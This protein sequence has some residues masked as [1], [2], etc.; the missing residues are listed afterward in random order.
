MVD[1]Y[2]GTSAINVEHNED[3]C[4]K[5]VQGLRGV[6]R[7][8]GTVPLRN[9]GS[10]SKKWRHWQPRIEESTVSSRKNDQIC[11]QRMSNTNS[12]RNGTTSRPRS[13]S[14]TLR[15]IAAQ[16]QNE[17]H[18]GGP[19][20]SS[21]FPHRSTPY[22]TSQQRS[23]TTTPTYTHTPTPIHWIL[24]SHHSS[25][26]F[27]ESLDAYF[28]WEG[29]PSFLLKLFSEIVGGHFLQVATA[30]LMYETV[31][32]TNIAGRRVGWLGLQ[33]GQCRCCLMVCWTSPVFSPSWVA[34]GFLDACTALIPMAEGDSTPWCTPTRPSCLGLD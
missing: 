15:S 11:R 25:T 14:R 6:P 24:D 2:E 26:T 19:L 12:L 34:K 22:G 20:P 28:R 32:I 8:K 7:V 9:D 5:A 1:N 29:P 4:Q 23:Q 21:F 3:H 30:D 33:C 31:M 27:L 16:L 17:K 13:T 18:F 10:R